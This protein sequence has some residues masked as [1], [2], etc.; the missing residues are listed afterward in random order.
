MEKV[1]EKVWDVKE[2]EVDR[3]GDKIWTVKKN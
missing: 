3:E 2:S 1:R